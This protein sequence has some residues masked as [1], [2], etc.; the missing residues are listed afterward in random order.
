MKASY[1]G[2][3]I[4]V[5][6]NTTA[7]IVGPVLVGTFVGKWL[8]QKFNTEPWLLLVSVGV[9]FIV[10]MFGLIANALK[11][12]KNIEKEYKKDEKE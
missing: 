2:K 3:I 8:D 7:W 6:V 9:C 10:S 5:L 11:E 4:G 12:F 1:S